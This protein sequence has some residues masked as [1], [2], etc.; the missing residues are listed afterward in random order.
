MKISVA[1]DIDLEGTQ[2]SGYV[3]WLD[4]T[5]VDGDQVRATARAAIVHVGEISDAAGEIWPALHGTPLEPIH[6]VYFA[7]GWYKDDYADGAGIDLFYLEA[8]EIAPG[9]Q[10]RARGRNLDLAIV[11]RLC[12]TL[13]SGC[14]L[15][16]VAYG[17]A[18]QAAK[19][20]RLGFAVSTPGRTSGLMHLKLGYRHAQVVDATGSG[21]YEVVPTPSAFMPARSA[22]N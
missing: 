6:D 4:I 12:D 16:V 17:D 20:G 7:H 13:G 21:D 19:W 15:A 11:R 14:Q 2:Q 22:A 5:V 10:N 3:T 9:P 1:A 8:I 18:E